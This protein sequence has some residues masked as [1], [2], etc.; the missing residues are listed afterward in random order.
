MGIYRFFLLAML[1][2]LVSRC[3][4]R[5]KPSAE[6]QIQPSELS[7]EHPTL[8]PPNIDE[9]GLKPELGA[10]KKESEKEVKESRLSFNEKLL[11]AEKDSA[12]ENFT[13]DWLG[14]PH[15]LG[16]L[17]KEGVD[18]SGFSLLAYS[19]VLNLDLTNRTSHGIFN[20][21]SAV[22]L[23][24]LS[25]GD[26]VFFKIKGNRIS[27]M[28]IYLQH[29]NFAHAS[30]SRGVMISNLALPYWKKRFY[31]GARYVQN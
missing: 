11:N 25:Y 9:P 26:L 23:D 22:A 28:G 17:S 2:W 18:C 5:I 21:L 14:T 16:G 6:S 29:G 12:F 19:Q 1:S 13:K 4:T 10:S 3:G 8:S 31:R 30:A 20:E 15:K 7:F 27:H 24:S